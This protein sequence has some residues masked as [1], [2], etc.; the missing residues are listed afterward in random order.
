[1]IVK[2]AIRDDFSKFDEENQSISDFS[3]AADG[4]T[5]QEKS[6]EAVVLTKFCGGQLVNFPVHLK[7]HKR[8]KNIGPDTSGLLRHFELALGTSGFDQEKN[9]FYL[10][11]VLDGSEQF[12]LEFPLMEK[13]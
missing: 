5:D 2:I 8:S 10:T 6:E 7:K 12:K 13:N 11:S 1:M 3:M 9:L 4:L